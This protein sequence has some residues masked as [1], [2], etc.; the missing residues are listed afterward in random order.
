MVETIV[1]IML[2]LLG[3]MLGAAAVFLLG[4]AA[5]PEMGRI[6]RGFAAGVMTA[7]SVWSLI[8]PALEQA[9]GMGTLRILPVGVGILT[10][11][12]FVE[13]LAGVL[14]RG[15][16]LTATA[17]AL[18]NLPEG[19]AVG[20]AAA[21][22]L[23]GGVGFASVAALS[24]GIAIQNLPEGIIVSAP[25]HAGGM[26]RLRAFGYGAASGVIEPVG[27]VLTIWLTAVA[28]PLL[29]WLLAF[30]AGAMLHV[31]VTE[32]I[33]KMDSRAGTAAFSL[34]FILMMALDV[35]LG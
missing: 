8:L 4:A 12:A 32:L 13:L 10:G 24:A 34:G 23:E 7:A 2:P 14:C 17:V 22:F 18:H 35:V 25:L 28:V 33:P 31:T 15:E 26:S 20:A 30:S 21:G 9:A 11:F 16:A 29:P 1:V 3:T 19:M 27:A 6:L 5:H